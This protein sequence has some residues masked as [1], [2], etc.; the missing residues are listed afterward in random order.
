MAGGEAVGKE[1]VEAIREEMLIEVS[2]R[3][4]ATSR[5]L[6]VPNSS[7]GWFSVM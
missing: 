1:T 5:D 7:R 2:E 3:L 4:S 6:K